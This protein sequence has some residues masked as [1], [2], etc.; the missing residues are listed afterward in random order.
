MCFHKCPSCFCYKWYVVFC[1]NEDP[2]CW[3]MHHTIFSGVSPSQDKSF[4]IYRQRVTVNWAKVT[5]AGLLEFIYLINGLIKTN[6]R[7]CSRAL[8][9]LVLK[10]YLHI[11]LLNFSIFHWRPW[12]N[13][14]CWLVTSSY[15]LTCRPLRLF[16]SRKLSLCQWQGNMT[17]EFQLCNMTFLNV[18]V[19]WMFEGRDHCLKP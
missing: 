14:P 15:G 8:L 11:D 3:Y 6:L 18:D 1:T 5:L 4:F 10:K 19:G 7:N 12:A 9:S 17:S 2:N 13:V 16:S